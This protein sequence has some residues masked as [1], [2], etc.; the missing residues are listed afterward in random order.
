MLAGEK[1][2]ERLE[3]GRSRPWVPTGRSAAGVRM[4]SSAR[5][6]RQMIPSHCTASRTC[7]TNAKDRAGGVGR[8][9][10]VVVGVL[11]MGGCV[12]KVSESTKYSE[13][14]EFGQRP[15]II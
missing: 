12:E 5:R 15:T 13:N 14:R 1:R 3:G 7:S 9:V 6:R 10:G 8:L 2:G 4:K 11:L